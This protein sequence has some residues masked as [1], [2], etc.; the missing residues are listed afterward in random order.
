M[1]WKFYELLDIP[2]DASKDDIKRAY[3]KKAVE[4]HPDKGGDPEKFK[5]I[6]NAYAVLSD[7]NQKNRYDQLGDEGF[8]ATGGTGGTGGGGMPV[9]PNDIFSQF[10]GNGFNFHF[11]HHHPGMGGGDQN[12]RRSDHKHIMKITLDEAFT[13]FT[14]NIRIVLQKTCHKCRDRCYACQGRGQ[15][16]EMHRMG[17]FT[18]MTSRPCGTCHG[19]GMSVKNNTGCG[20]CKGVGN[21]NQENIMEINI[22]AG[23]DNGFQVLFKEFGEQPA[24]PTETAGDLI[25]EIQIIPHEQFTRQGNDLHYKIPISFKNSIIGTKINI[26]HFSGNFQFNTNDL[27]I[28]QNTKQYIIRQKGMPIRD[29]NPKEFGNM[30]ISFEIQYPTIKIK[31]DDAIR[32]KELFDDIGII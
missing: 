17:F 30:I 21:Y 18:Q 26:Q 3:K 19:I 13:G 15:I 29:S 20:D 2:R 27:G 23:V 9:D 16:T 28:I 25:I 1:T 7:D 10:F 6:G 14:K 11:Q 8:A 4:T 12:V 22:P 24:K 32:I 5:E 31:Q